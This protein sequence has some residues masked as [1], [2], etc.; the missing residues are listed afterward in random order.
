MLHVYKRRYLVLNKDQVWTRELLFH[1]ILGKALKL[2][3]QPTGGTAL[4]WGVGE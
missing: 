2:K 1:L 4:E 3:K